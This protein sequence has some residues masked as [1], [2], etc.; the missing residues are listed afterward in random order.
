MT[1][2]REEEKVEHEMHDVF[3]SGLATMYFQDASLLE[4]QKRLQSSKQRNNL[5]TMFAVESIPSDTQ[6]RDVMDK[7]DSKEL[8]PIFDDLFRLLQRGKHLEGYRVFGKYHACV[9]DGSEYFG[10]E[11]IRCPSCL[12][13]EVKKKRENSV[14][15]I[16]Q[17][18]QAA[19]IHPRKSQVIPLPPEEIKNT[20][21]KEKQDCEI[22]AAK[23]LLKKI[24]ESHPKL[25]LIIIA[26]SLHS[27]QPVIELILSLRNMRYILTAKPDDH[28]KLMEWVN[29]QRLLKEVFRMEMKDRKDRTHIYEWINDVP[30]NGN[31]DAPSVNYFEYRI[32]DGDRPVYH[33]SW[34]TDFAVDDENVE[35]LVELGRCR[36]M[37][38]NEV[39]NT[40]KN[41]GYHIEHNYGHGERHLSMNFFL[42]NMLAFFMH[43]IFELAD[44]LYQWLRKKLGSKK[45]L[46]DHLRIACHILIFQSWEVLLMYI[47][48]DYGYT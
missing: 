25:S 34:V 42:L 15:Y 31:D 35:Q 10:S 14:R 39:F 24:R 43:Q 44:P 20:D 1:D 38:E 28:K 16:H 48:E 17:I 22:N 3:M 7:V 2:H 29:E 4:F 6:M 21:G 45:N 19:I 32:K 26:D 11:K 33:N 46:W 47:A 36:W 18:M 5:K 40:V 41:Q 12:T 8:K 9:M 37:I 27:K 23:R 13:R 30:L